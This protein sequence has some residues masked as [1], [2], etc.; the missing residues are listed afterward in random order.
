LLLARNVYQSCQQCFE[1]SRKAVGLT[2]VPQRRHKHRALADCDAL[3]ES[4]AFE[5]DRFD[6]EF[7]SGIMGD[8]LLMAKSAVSPELLVVNAGIVAAR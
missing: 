4:A 5:L 8:G 6:L 1:F 3:Y 2:S 7:H